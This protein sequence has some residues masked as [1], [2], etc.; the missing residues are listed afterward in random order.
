MN[1]GNN[2]VAPTV[3]SGNTWN[4]PDAED[5][6]VTFGSETL[7]AGGGSGVVFNGDPGAGGIATGG[8]VNIAGSVGGIASASTPAFDELGFSILTMVRY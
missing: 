5:V 3:S 4:G 1:G 8:Q 7:T 2:G 6:V